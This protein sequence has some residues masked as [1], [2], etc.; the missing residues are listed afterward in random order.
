MTPDNAP[1]NR[2]W[3]KQIATIATKLCV[4]LQN[5]DAA[6]VARILTDASRHYGAQLDELIRQVSETKAAPPGHPPDAT[7]RVALQSVFGVFLDAEVHSL[8]FLRASG[9]DTNRVVI[10]FFKKVLCRHGLLPFTDYKGLR[11]AVATTVEGVM[12]KR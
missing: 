3:L 4:A 6:S 10:E 1:Q 9:A 5:G 11:S 2:E 8:C 7:R 12:K